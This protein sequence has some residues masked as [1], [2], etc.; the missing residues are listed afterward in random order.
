MSA[1]TISSLPGWFG[2]LPGLGDFGDWWAEPIVWQKLAVWTLL[3]EIIGLGCG[4]MPLTFRFSPMIGGVL[5]WLRPGTVRLPPWPRKV[6]LTRG[7]TRTILD[8]GLYAGVLGSALYLLLSDGEEVAGLGAGRLDPAA[9]AVL[10]GFLGL[11]GLRDKVAF[12]GARVEVYGFLLV[13]FLFP[14]ENLMDGILAMLGRVAPPDVLRI[15]QEQI[16]KIAQSNAGG[17]LTLDGQITP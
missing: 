14:V 16:V 15:V 11:L 5:Y 12:L 4:S 8:V 17:I 3:W 7:T 13:V 6:P 1:L 2:K 9:I 10:L